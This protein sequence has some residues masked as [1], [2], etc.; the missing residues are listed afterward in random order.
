[1]GQG[2][3]KC[4]GCDVVPD[5]VAVMRSPLVEQ[6]C[7]CAETVC[8]LGLRVGA[9]RAAANTATAEELRDAVGIL[10]EKAGLRDPSAQGALLALQIALC[11]DPR[12]YSEV[13]PR[14]TVEGVTDE[15][16]ALPVPDYG[17]GRAP[18]LGERKSLARRPDRK[19]VERVLRDP[20][21]D[22]IALLLKNPRLTEADVVRLCARRPNTAEVLRQVFCD[23]RWSS[24]PR[25]RNALALN[26]STP[27][28]VVHAVLP[29]LAPDEILDIARDDR[30]SLAVRRR[31]L[32][33]LARL[34]PSE[35]SSGQM[36]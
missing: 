19:F 7:R 29:L 11:A 20:H 26:P 32:E 4:M 30:A 6:L 3:F 27:E 22:V 17:R 12:W 36:H 15:D 21:P 31:C 34:R 10:V 25:V 1:M 24:R 18:T 16:D 33:V 5:S 23:P 9:S 13:F 28:P 8:D 14:A 35:D 2:M